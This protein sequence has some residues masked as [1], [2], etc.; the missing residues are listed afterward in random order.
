M[1]KQMFRLFDAYAG[2]YSIADSIYV[3]LRENETDD[4]T[5][6][7]ERGTCMWSRPFFGLSK[8]ILFRCRDIV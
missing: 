3:S 5:L 7:A 6:D 4:E 8:P 2:Q 1:E